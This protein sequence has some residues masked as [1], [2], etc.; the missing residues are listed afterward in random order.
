MPTVANTAATSPTTSTTSVTNPNATI[1]K[2]G[3]LKLFVAQLQNQD[4]TSPT[5][6]SDSVQQMTSFTMVE[7]LTN[8]ASD[9]T[10][11]LKSI[12]T[13]NAIGLIGRTVDYAGT[14]GSTQTGKVES[15]STTKDGAST[16]TI[17]GQTGIDP[18]SIISVA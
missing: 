2:D 11:I 1:D 16:L 13:S 5:D 10:K 12:N 18:T 8:M 7:Q 9:N 3:F 14:D 6:A 4:P 17:A 15:V